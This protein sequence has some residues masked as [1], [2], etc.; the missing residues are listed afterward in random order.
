M[1]VIAGSAKGR[2]LKSLPGPATRPILARIKKSL[3]DIIRLKVPESMFLDLFAGT[4]SVGIEA[5]SRGAKSC[6]FIEKDHHTAKIIKENLFL[7]GFA[8]RGQ[9]LIGS[10]FEL[11]KNLGQKYDIIFMGPPYKMEAVGNTI[12]LIENYQLLSKEGIAV[13]QHHFKER[14]S[15]EIG[16]L[17]KVREEKYG[18]TRLSFYS[19]QEHL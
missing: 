12:T 13:A 16:A 3:F 9:I 14:A 11:L 2:R 10:V 4:G 7:T 8:D 1:Y 18:D 19:F 17:H 6:V 15:F 5:L